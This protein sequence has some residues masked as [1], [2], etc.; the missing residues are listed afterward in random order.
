MQLLAA[1]PHE[2]LVIGESEW[3]KQQC[4]LIHVVVVLIDHHDLDS[5]VVGPM[6][7]VVA[8]Q[9]VGTQGASRTAAE[10]DDALGHEASFQPHCRPA[11]EARSGPKDPTFQGVEGAPADQ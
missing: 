3:N 7:P 9:P 10:D 11:S 8:V 6:G 4:G 5:L 1:G 2:L